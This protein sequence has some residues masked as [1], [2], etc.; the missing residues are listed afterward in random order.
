MVEEIVT[1]RRVSAG[2]AASTRDRPVMQQTMRS[3]EEWNRA[4]TAVNLKNMLQG[5]L[6]HVAGAQKPL[7]G[8]SKS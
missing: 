8:A 1:V 7:N 6:P 5:A 2:K 4:M 3:A